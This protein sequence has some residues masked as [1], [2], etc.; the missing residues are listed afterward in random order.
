MR[1]SLGFAPIA[2]L[3]TATAWLT[4][5]LWGQSPYGRYIDHP[6]W[7]E[8]GPAAIIC[9]ALPAGG[10]LVPL[11]LYAGGWVLMTAGMMLPTIIPLLDR[12]ERLVGERPDG[13][14]LFWLVVSG[15]LAAWGA[16]GVAAHL[17][18]SAVHI[19]LEQ[20]DW[21]SLHGWAP[22]A[23]ILAVAGVFQFSRL[24]YRCLAKCRAPFSFIAKHWRGPHPQRDAF[25]L[26][27]D[28]GV[29]CVGCCWAIMLLMFVVGMGSVGWMLAL[30]AVMA[31]EKNTRWGARLTTP[32][33]SALLLAA[34]VIAGVNLAAWPG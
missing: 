21:L 4:L 16:F 32:L 5:W 12:F 30:G 18:D 2:A 19:G 23:A 8:F 17:L 7:T 10:L 3:L 28:H 33:G 29:F 14:R 25:L 1:R 31:I 6:G 26:G 11:M 13:R 24:K 20:W 34:A 27:L 15:Y 22:G 9:H